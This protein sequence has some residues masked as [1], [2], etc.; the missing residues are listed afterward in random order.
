MQ[1]FFESEII[2]QK[3]AD[4]IA[5]D[6][7][8]LAK[9]YYSEYKNMYENCTGKELKVTFEELINVRESRNRNKEEEIEEETEE[10][11]ENER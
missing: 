1:K 4:A 8:D 7:D 10:K 5:N 11:E 9:K 6:E 3:L 2:L